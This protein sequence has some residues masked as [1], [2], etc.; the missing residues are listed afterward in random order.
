MADNDEQPLATSEDL[1]TCELAT[2]DLV[3][4]AR[5]LVL[6]T[7]RVD[8]ARLALAALQ[9][10]GAHWQLRLDAS[11]VLAR[12]QAVKRGLVA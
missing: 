7:Q 12:A 3:P 1:Q 11:N 4:L 8:A 5:Q 10:I 2:A 9:L 6:A